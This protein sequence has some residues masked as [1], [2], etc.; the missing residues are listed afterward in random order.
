MNVFI[1]RSE[2]SLD[3][4]GSPDVFGV[5]GEKHLAH[6]AILEAWPQAKVS[7]HNADC[8][9]INKYEEAYIE[10]WAVIDRQSQNSTVSA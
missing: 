2:S 6:A 8:Y 9:A 3:Y 1:V 4:E 10:E 7:K 5:F